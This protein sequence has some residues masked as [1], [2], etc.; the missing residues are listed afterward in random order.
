VKFGASYALASRYVTFSIWLTIAVIAL[1]AIITTEMAKGSRS[2][3]ARL[4]VWA[5]CLGLIAAFLVPYKACAANTRFFLR[6]LSAKDRL[7]R[8][9]VFFSPVIDTSEIIKKTVY[10]GEAEPV[11]R[12]SAALDRL[13]LLRPP[14]LRTKRLSGIAH[15][16]ASGKEATGVCDAVAPVD[17]ER[18]RAKGWAALPAQSRPADCVAVAYQTESDPDPILFALSDTF[19]MRADVVKRFR[20]MDQLWSG[21]AVTFPQSAVPPGAKLSFWAVDAD[22]PKLYQLPDDSPR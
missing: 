18:I 15:E 22:R 10:P 11:L 20:S 8:G 21:W 7:G 3:R 19:E 5:V 16:V 17:G 6:A 12:H 1:V 14:L 2:V 4:G 13:K 9:A